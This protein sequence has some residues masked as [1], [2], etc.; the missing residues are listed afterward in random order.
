MAQTTRTP[1]YPTNSLLWPWKTSTLVRVL[2]ELGP[3]L[4]L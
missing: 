3:W 2:S 1:N 4:R